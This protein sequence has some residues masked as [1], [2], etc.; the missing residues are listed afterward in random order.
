MSHD[1]QVNKAEHN[2]RRNITQ[3]QKGT[4]CLSMLR[5]LKTLTSGS[6]QTQKPC[7]LPHNRNKG[8]CRAWAGR[9][10]SGE[11]LASRIHKDN[12]SHYADC[13]V[14]AGQQGSRWTERQWHRPLQR[15][16]CLQE[17]VSC[18][19]LQHSLENKNLD[20]GY[21]RGPRA[22]VLNLRALTPLGFTYWISCISDTCII[23]H[24]CSKLQL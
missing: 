6:R 20:Q 3:P 16:Q 12:G 22:V 13:C 9:C 23:I 15:D 10:R 1:G 24:D 7:V 19:L 14:I 4:A 11:G 2:T 17:P 5:I 18:V 21:S 8:D